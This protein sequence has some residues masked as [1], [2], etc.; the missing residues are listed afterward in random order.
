MSIGVGV[1]DAAATSF[2]DGTSA[3]FPGVADEFADDPQPAAK[4][5]TKIRMKRDT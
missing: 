4:S 2:A 5:R 1:S 3:P